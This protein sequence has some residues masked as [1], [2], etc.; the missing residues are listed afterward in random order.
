MPNGDQAEWTESANRQLRLMLL[1][2]RSPADA[3]L[4][5]GRS[6]PAVVAQLRQLRIVPSGRR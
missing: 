1:R 5:P 2:R 3:A 6:L 4:R